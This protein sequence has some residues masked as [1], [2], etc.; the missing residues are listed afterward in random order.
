MKFNI[1]ANTRITDEQKFRDFIHQYDIIPFVTMKFLS[2]KQIE[3]MDNLHEYE[4]KY[5]FTFR[6]Y[7]LLGNIIKKY[8]DD[9]ESSL[10]DFKSAL[11]VLK[12][13]KDNDIK[14][15]FSSVSTEKISFENFRYIMDILSQ[16]MSPSNLYQFIANQ[17]EDMINERIIFRPHI[18]HILSNLS[19]CRHNV[20]NVYDPIAKDMESIISLDEF[21]HATVYISGQEGY[22][23]AKQC[24]IINE[25]PLDKVSL[26]IND[27]IVDDSKEKYDTII[28]ISPYFNQLKTKISTEYNKKYKTDNP[29]LLHILNM[30]D[31][32]DD[33]AVII[34]IVPNEV[35]VKKDGYNLRKS[36][37][38]KNLL[39]AVIEYESHFR[40]EKYMILVINNYKGC[41]DF[42]FI[43]QK[44]PMNGL[45]LN[46][47][48][49]KCYEERKKVDNFSNIIS[50]EQ[51]IAND[52]NL[53]PKRY[54]Y[55]LEYTPEPVEEIVK[56]QKEYSDELNKLNVEIGK[57]LDRLKE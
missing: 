31:H 54:V 15:V 53:N 18:Y 28:S 10:G 47:E 49:L 21:N 6:D 42:F 55:T 19:Q 8:E 11:T 7:E 23:H 16:D 13:S 38:E 17:K 45:K 50:K 5:G 51:I 14:E 3:Y 9:D 29:I 24:F 22:L 36:L 34:T 44:N 2:Q 4:K 52:Y 43:K 32:M 57:L 48:I 56:K 26:E 20:R 41:D 25:I 33:K 40:K 12:N 35:L 37:V 1:K 46:D 39:D 27:A 30:I